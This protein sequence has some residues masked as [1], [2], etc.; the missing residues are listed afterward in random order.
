MNIL[1]QVLFEQLISLA[2][3]SLD[4]CSLNTHYQ[5]DLRYLKEENQEVKGKI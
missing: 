4:N 5:S 2:A 3:T 1:L